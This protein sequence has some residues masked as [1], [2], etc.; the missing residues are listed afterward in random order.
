MKSD[1]VKAI[2]REIYF[3]DSVANRVAQ[4]TGARLIEV[5]PSV[6]GEKGTDDYFALI[7][8]IVDKIGAALK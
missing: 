7:E 8:H 4:Q 1:G 2:L 3:A 6:G 5:P